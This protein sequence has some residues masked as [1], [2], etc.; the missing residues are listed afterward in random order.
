M[1]RAPYTAPLAPRRMLSSRCSRQA[2]RTC[3]VG[4]AGGGKNESST[5]AQAAKQ[6]D[7]HHGAMGHAEHANEGRLDLR[8][9]PLAAMSAVTRVRAKSRG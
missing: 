2:H 9:A 3:A 8:A 1:V 5:A 7:G 4:G 6:A